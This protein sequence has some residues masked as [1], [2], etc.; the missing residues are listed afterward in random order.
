MIW[1]GVSY[2]VGGEILLGQDTSQGIIFS[3]GSNINE[4]RFIEYMSVSTSAG[5]GLGGSGSMNLVVVTNVDTEDQITQCFSN[6]YEWDY[7]LDMV[8]SGASKHLLSIPQQMNKLHRLKGTLGPGMNLARKS[9]NLV[10]YYGD[11]KDAGEAALGSVKGALNSAQGKPT[12]IEIPLGAGMRVSLK[13]KK[14]EGAA[15]SSGVIRIAD[16]GVSVT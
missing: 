2:S 4:L 12:L 1:F 3:S 5:L 15:L 13:K 6:E 14:T 10:Q 9:A 7:S 16:D 8:I 11:L